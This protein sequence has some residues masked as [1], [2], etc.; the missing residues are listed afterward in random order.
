MLGAGPGLAGRE[1]KPIK[2]LRVLR[3]VEPDVEVPSAASAPGELSSPRGCVAGCLL[4]V[5]AGL[6]GFA[7]AVLQNN[8]IVASWSYCFGMPAGAV[9]DSGDSLGLGFDFLFRVSGYGIC[10]AAGMAVGMWATRR[11]PRLVRILAG[12]GLALLF[13]ALAFWADYALNNG[14]GP[15]YVSPRCP[16][17]RPPWWPSWVPLRIRSS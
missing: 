6:G 7:L 4:A 5:V 14:L 8:G 15:M 9:V 17:G 16:Q 2:S 10:L 11:R 13:A 3:V 12:F 1:G